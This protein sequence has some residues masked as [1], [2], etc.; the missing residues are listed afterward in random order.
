[1][2]SFKGQDK[3]QWAEHDGGIGEG[4]DREGPDKGSET[5]HQGGI[6]IDGVIHL[7]GASC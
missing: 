2:I 3:G 4:P 5:G 6:D 1:M 7:K